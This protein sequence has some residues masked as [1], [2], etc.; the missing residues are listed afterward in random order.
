MIISGPISHHTW[1]KY[2]LVIGICE[3]KLSFP[4]PSQFQS[5]S[6][7]GILRWIGFKYVLKGHVLF[8]EEMIF[9]DDIK[10]YSKQIFIR[11]VWISSRLGTK[12]YSRE[13][14]LTLHKP[15]FEYP[16]LCLG[17]CNDWKCFRVSNVN[18]GPVVYLTIYLILL[19]DKKEEIKANELFNVH[20]VWVF[21]LF[22]DRIP[23][24]LYV[25][26]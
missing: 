23:I 11:T 22:R 7:H 4:E 26:F 24:Q 12:Q 9:I 10:R 14:V 8:E 2:P 25:L 21:V 3:N 16:E 13:T 17:L 6:V 15:A 1:Q 5:N 19:F 20:N 18:S